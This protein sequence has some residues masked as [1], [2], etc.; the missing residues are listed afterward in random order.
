MSE[1][2]DALKAKIE[3]VRTQID[4][5]VEELI[6][7]GGTLRERAGEALKEVSESLNEIVESIEEDDE[8]EEAGEGA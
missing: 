2:G 8:V 6:S 7:K 3:Q 4:A 1:A 5:V